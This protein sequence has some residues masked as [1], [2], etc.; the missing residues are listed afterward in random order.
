MSTYELRNGIGYRPDADQRGYRQPPAGARALR[1]A[2]GPSG[3]TDVLGNPV[4]ASAFGD[5]CML[6]K[7]SQPISPPRS[8]SGI[9]IAKTVSA[10]RSPSSAT[11]PQLAA[12]KLR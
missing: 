7:S 9:T 10:L 4:A 6:V 12:W 11:R 5:F 3:C 2:A 1:A 8:N